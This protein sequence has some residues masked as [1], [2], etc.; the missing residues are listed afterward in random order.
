MNAEAK[1]TCIRLNIQMP[2][3]PRGTVPVN[4]GSSSRLLIHDRATVFSARFCQLLRGA[5]AERLVWSIREECLDQMVFFGEGAL[6]RAAEEFVAHYNGERNHQSLD[7][8]I[9]RPERSEFPASGRVC[10]RRRLGGLL[11]YYYQ[12]A[13]G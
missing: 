10:R 9:I 6:R 8:K 13:I 12:A 1:F 4:P 3:P 5:Y 2:C 11:N 7:N